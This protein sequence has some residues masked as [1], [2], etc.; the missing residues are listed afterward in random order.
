MLKENYYLL[1]DTFKTKEVRRG[2]RRLQR[3]PARP[4]GKGM[5]AAS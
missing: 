1:A 3:V 2:I 4:S 5:Q